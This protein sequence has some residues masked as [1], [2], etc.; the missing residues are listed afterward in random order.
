MKEK[1]KFSIKFNF[2]FFLVCA[3]LLFADTDG[4]AMLS[5][6]ACMLHEGGHLLAMAFFSVR[7]ERI[8]FYGGGISIAKNLD[9][10]TFAQKMLILSAGCVTNAL[11]AL[12][13]MLFMP[14][15]GYAEVF[16]AV[17]I[18]ILTFNLLP[19]GY[20]DG[21]QMLDTVLDRFVGYKTALT[22]KKAAGVIISAL[23]IAGVTA[24]SFCYNET[25]SLS[26]GFAVLYLLI[27]QFIE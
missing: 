21:A 22:V 20:F 16:A 13:C 18:L 8:T 17:N 4:T 7:P 10:C 15:N 24:Y 27:S 3:L 1:F 25:V 9:A 23:I 2:T 12:S 11:I 6:I 5:L 26:L 19:L 14:D